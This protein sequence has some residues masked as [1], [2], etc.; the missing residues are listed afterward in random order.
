MIRSRLQ[1][2]FLAP[3]DSN[4]EKLCYA[5]LYQI[6]LNGRGEERPS[7]PP[8]FLP[9]QLQGHEI[10]F[11]MTPCQGMASPRHLQPQHATTT[12][13]TVRMHEQRGKLAIGS[14]LGP[15]LSIF[16][17]PDTVTRPLPLHTIKG[18]GGTLNGGERQKTTPNNGIVL[19]TH[20]K[21][22][23]CTHS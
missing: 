3:H 5:T 18:Q 22:L 1:W 14:T 10:F 19:S 15:F 11:I 13:T 17:L 23:K 6:H 21:T 9:M 8:T 20:P 2:I 7:K 4:R 12:T 16:V